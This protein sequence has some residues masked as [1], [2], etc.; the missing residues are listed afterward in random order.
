MVYDQGV[1]GLSYE[2]KNWPA[3]CPVL[4]NLLE[5]SWFPDRDWVGEL[6]AQNKA[7]PL[8]KLSEDRI[9]Q[10]ENVIEE[11]SERLPVVLEAWSVLVHPKSGE[12]FH[13]G[14]ETQD[15]PELRQLADNLGSI[16]KLLAIDNSF[17]VTVS[18]AFILVVPEGPYSHFCAVFALSLAKKTLALTESAEGADL[19][20]IIRLLP[21]YKENTPDKMQTIEGVIHQWVATKLTED[22]DWFERVRAENFGDQPNNAR[23]NIEKAVPLLCALLRE[24]NCYIEPPINSPEEASFEMEERYDQLLVSMDRVSRALTAGESLVRTALQTVGLGG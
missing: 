5:Q 17:S 14:I 24:G 22:W 7:Q 23:N 1:D 16:F 4:E 9:N 13:V 6:I 21:E 19:R 10:L 2:V 8:L 12:A 18:E 20:E 3:L 15:F 11:V